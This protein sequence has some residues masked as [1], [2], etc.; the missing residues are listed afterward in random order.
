MFAHLKFM[1]IGVNFINVKRMPFL[2]EH[3]FGSFFYVH[4]TR[5]KAAEMTFMQKM[6]TFNN[7]EIDSW[8]V[9][10]SP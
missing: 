3:H 4:V 2:Y 10:L 8:L 9:K 7:D 5:K 1:N 6:R